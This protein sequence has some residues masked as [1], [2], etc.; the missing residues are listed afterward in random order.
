[1]VDIE[2][3]LF[4]ISDA[5]KAARKQLRFASPSSRRGPRYGFFSVDLASASF[6]RRQ[7]KGNHLR[8]FCNSSSILNASPGTEF[9]SKSDESLRNHSR[10]FD[11]RLVSPIH[12]RRDG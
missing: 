3:R 8:N 5:L 2:S 4:V 12:F 10:D 9:S 6:G 7:F 1:M 11:S